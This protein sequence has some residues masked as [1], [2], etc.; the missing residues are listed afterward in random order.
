MPRYRSPWMD[1]DLDAVREL[2]R[3][4]FETE[5]PANITPPPPGTDHARAEFAPSPATGTHA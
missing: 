2:S 4:F 5:A 1:S 3:T